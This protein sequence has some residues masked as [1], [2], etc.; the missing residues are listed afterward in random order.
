MLNNLVFLLKTLYVIIHNM[1]KLSSNNL[2]Y[3]LMGHTG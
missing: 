3:L 2:K 1:Y